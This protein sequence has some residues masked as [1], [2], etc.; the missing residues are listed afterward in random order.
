M[1]KRGVVAVCYGQAGAVSALWGTTLPATDARL[2]LGAGRLGGVLMAMAAGA[3][4]AMPAAGWLAD[5]FGGTRVLRLGA[6]AAAVVLIG[7]AVA[8]SVMALGVAAFVLGI[9]V[10][11]LNVALSAQAVA[12]ERA[13]GRPIMA[14]MHGTW[15]LGAVAVGGMVYLGLRTGIDSQLLMI[16]GVAPLLAIA[17]SASR[18]LT[19]EPSRPPQHEAP[20]AP[21]AP[22]ASGAPP[23]PNAARPAVPTAPGAVGGRRTGVSSWVVVALGIVGAASFVAEGAATD[24]A[25][26]HATRM[27]EA[28][29]STAALGYT[30]FFV[31]MTVIRF[32]GDALRAR[33]GA[34]TTIRLAAGTATVGYALVLLAGTLPT[35]RSGRIGC[36]LA[37]WALAGVGIA[38]VWPVVTSG[39]GA[40]ATAGQP[41][42]AGRLA[43]VTAIS[44]GAGLI[45]PALI[46]FVAEQASLSTALIIPAALT[47]LVSAAAPAIL[48][49]LDLTGNQ[50]TSKPPICSAS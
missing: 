46:G 23:Q 28:D 43:A 21:S 36:A 11:V 33:L 17:L 18:N 49:Q 6:C 26:V 8:P 40:A 48:R 27:L 47:A 37:G 24:W 10:G 5:R 44:Y 9:S 3:L 42:S 4:I 38:V 31:A 13:V 41:A 25:G 19:A 15:T 29:P 2:D 35:D 45:G 20:I 1:G 30:V 39:L 12:V 7:P 16:A 14:T 34:A 22:S 50:P 32:I